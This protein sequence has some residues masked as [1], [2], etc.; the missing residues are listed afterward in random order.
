[1]N[2]LDTTTSTTFSDQSLTPRARDMACWLCD[3][4]NRAIQVPIRRALGEA[5]LRELP[6]HWTLD[7][8]WAES[9]KILRDIGPKQSRCSWLSAMGWLV[10]EEERLPI[11]AE[12]PSMHVVRARVMPLMQK[13]LRELSA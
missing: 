2:Y 11:K 3:I 9:A 5:L 7:E 8:L 4:S 1:V 10:G 12:R 13:L 6:D